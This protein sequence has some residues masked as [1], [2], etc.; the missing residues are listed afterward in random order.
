MRDSS[1][2]GC[3]APSLC[4]YS[5]WGEWSHREG[6][7]PCRAWVCGWSV[8]PGEIHFYS[9]WISKHRLELIGMVMRHVL[10]PMGLELWTWIALSSLTLQEVMDLGWLVHDFS[11]HRLIAG[12][13][14]PTLAVWQRRLTMSSLMVTG[15]WSTTAGSTRVLSSSKL[16]RG[17]L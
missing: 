8:P 9:W 4:I 3:R 1:L 15:G 17:L 7:I 13:G 16:T 11:T 10:V 2:F 14:I 12:L 5:D 6:S